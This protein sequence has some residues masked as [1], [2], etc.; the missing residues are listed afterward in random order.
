VVCSQVS[1]DA[2]S[3]DDAA[4][5]EAIWQ[6]ARDGDREGLREL[7]YALDWGYGG[8]IPD[9]TIQLLVDALLDVAFV[10]SPASQCAG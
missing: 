2:R 8:R 10:S 5:R 3:I 9:S 6:A 1:E 7:A 4:A